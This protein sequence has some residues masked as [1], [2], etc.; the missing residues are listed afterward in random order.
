MKDIF[1]GY[2]NL[3]YLDSSNFNTENVTNM[4]AIFG[5]YN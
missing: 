4:K 2:I 3:K 1:S 5:K